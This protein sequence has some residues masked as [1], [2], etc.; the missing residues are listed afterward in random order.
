MVI[1][2]DPEL[3]AALTAVASRCGVAPEVLALDALRDRFLGTA[4]RLQPQHE[5]ER[6][7]L[8]L[9]KDCGVSLP[10]SAFRRE[11]FAKNP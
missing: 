7:L 8:G 5:W 1:S 2:L 6:Q 11:T 10:D 3:E 4:G 9:T